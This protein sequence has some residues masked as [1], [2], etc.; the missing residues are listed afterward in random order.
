VGLLFLLL[1]VTGVALHSGIRVVSARKRGPVTHEVPMKRVYMYSQYE[2]VW[3]WVMALSIILLLLTGFQ[4][5]FPG[6]ISVIKFA[7]AI[8]LHNIMAAVLIINSFLSLFFHLATAEIRQFV[9]ER[10]G[11]VR[12]VMIQGRYY[13][14]GIFQGA[15]HPIRKTPEYKLNPL[16]Q[17]TYAGLL[18]FLFPLQISTG[19]LLWVGGLMPAVLVPIGGLAILAPVHNLGS[20]LFLS[21][22]VIHVYLTTTGHTV[23]SNLQAMVD[24]WEY[25]ESETEVKT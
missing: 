6:H 4:I 25:I 14:Q 22:L 13:L 12:R 1:T 2:R 15:T 8:L 10:T 11:L 23:T 19:I 24:G 9:P 17:L 16:Q 7:T 5:H 18:N 21:F 3:H 20:W